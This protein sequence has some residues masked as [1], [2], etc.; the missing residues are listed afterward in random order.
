MWFWTRRHG[1]VLSEYLEKI[2]SG[3]IEDVAG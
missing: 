1:I 3:A 2:K